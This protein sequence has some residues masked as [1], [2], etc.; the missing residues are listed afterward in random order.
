MEVALKTRKEVVSS[1]LKLNTLVNP[2]AP[3]SGTPVSQEPLPRAKNLNVSL[4]LV[5]AA[6]QALLSSQTC[7]SE[8]GHMPRAA[9]K[10][11]QDPQLFLGL[12]PVLTFPAAIH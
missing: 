1:P 10:G 2:L 11:S 6:S 8:L 3:I 5:P 9:W 12:K 4:G 7:P